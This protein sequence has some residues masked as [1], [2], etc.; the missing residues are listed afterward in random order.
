MKDL[1]TPVSAESPFKEKAAPLNRTAYTERE[2]DILLSLSSAIATIRNKTDLF[3]VIDQKLKTLFSFE[4]FVI[5]TI[6]EDRLTHSAFL[7]NQQE[8]FQN[9]PGISPRSNKSYPLDDGLCHLL[10]ATGGP[11]VYN[12]D[13]VMQWDHTPPWLSFWQQMGIKEMIGLCLSDEHGPTG[14]FY[15]FS[16]EEGAVQHL[17]YRL[18][19]NIGQQIGVAVSNIRANEKI[20]EQ[21]QQINLYKQQLEGEKIYLEEQINTSNNYTDIIGQSTAIK[22]VFHLIDQVAPA[23]STVLITGETGTG[24]ELVA[25]AIHKGSLRKKKLLIKL[26]C[27]TLP[28]AMAE[29]E[30]FGHEKGSFTGAIDRK[31]GKFELANGG[32]L[33]LDEI[34]E[35]S[36][37][38]QAKL[39]RALQEKEIE[40]IGGK[41][42]IHTDVRIV[43]ATNRNL[44]EDVRA[45]KFRS[46]LYYRLNV[47]PIQLPPLRD[48]KEDIP[49]LTKHFL[50]HFAW[51]TGKEKK[52][53]NALM[54]KKL[55]NYSWPGNIRELEHVMERSI[56]LTTTKVITE[57]YL[58]E[59][60]MQELNGSSAALA[61]KSIEE[62]ERDHILEV[63]KRCKGKISGKGGAAE[64][65]QVPATTLNSKM[66]KLKIKKGLVLPS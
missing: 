61:V 28:Q 3:K 43:A 54:V 41:S 47:F 65:L 24:K 9:K 27:A 19:K 33:F 8:S 14:F 36:P 59:I 64:L 18:L 62:N 29:S 16:K 40:R 55:K 17:Y 4:E 6:S 7:Y 22:K 2:T 66:K 48:R 21:L 34:G 39:L 20:E 25:R 15:I 10:Q 60:E 51:K 13:Q 53:I 26:N 23:D 63:L 57:V 5:C 35:L 32:T 49:A 58:P 46:D 50:A 45:G 11:E 52:A 42:V 31:I 1:S 37:E 12:V 30:L 38:L 56:L 44:L